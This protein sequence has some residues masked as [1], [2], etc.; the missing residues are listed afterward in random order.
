[1]ARTQSPKRVAITGA[2]LLSPVGNDLASSWQALKEGKSGV[3]PITRFDASA[4]KTKIAA[5]LKGFA[6]ENYMDKKAVKR[7]DPFIQYAVAAAKMA[8]AERPRAYT[9]TR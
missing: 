8:F 5:E 6:P 3:G 2:A 1:M 9:I 7:F 4:Q